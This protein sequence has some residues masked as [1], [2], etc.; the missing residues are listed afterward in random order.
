[1]NDAVATTYVVEVVDGIEIETTSAFVAE[2][3]SR[4]GS[5]VTARTER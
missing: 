5:R 1:M 4:A 2:I 3:E